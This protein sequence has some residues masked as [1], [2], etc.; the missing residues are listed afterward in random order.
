MTGPS[1]FSALSGVRPFRGTTPGGS[2]ACSPGCTEQGAGLAE[3]LSLRS[4]RSEA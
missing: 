1:R 2:Q 3:S 4:Y